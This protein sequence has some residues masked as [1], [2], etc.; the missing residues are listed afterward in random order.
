MKTFFL[1]PLP[2]CQQPQ[3]QSSF[4]FN[5]ENVI[6]WLI[7][8]TVWSPIPAAANVNGE[9]SKVIDFTHS[10]LHWSHSNCGHSDDNDDLWN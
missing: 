10:P 5:H 7:S 2:P 3:V 6:E 8:V 9:I 1:S 4:F